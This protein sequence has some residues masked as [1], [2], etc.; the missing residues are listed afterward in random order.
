MS[1]SVT[2]GTQLPEDFGHASSLKELGMLDGFFE[3]RLEIK[4]RIST[5]IRVLLKKPEVEAKIEKESNVT[6]DASIKASA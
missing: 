6:V 1:A 3:S 5:L 4:G 2:K